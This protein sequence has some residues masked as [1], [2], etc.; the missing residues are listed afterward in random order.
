MKKSK[1]LFLSSLAI[2]TPSITG[3]VAISC[4]GE[5]ANQFADQFVN[6]SN[7]TK[8]WSEQ[9]KTLDLSKADI[10]EIPDGA[11]SFKAL[12]NFAIIRSGSNV[13]IGNIASGLVD[14]ELSKSNTKIGVNGF[15]IE[16]LILPANLEKIGAGAFSGLGKIKTVVFGDK[17]TTIGDEAFSQNAIEKLELP[18][19]VSYIG[20]RAF[21]Q[22]A[23]ASL[24]L[25]AATKVTIL[26]EGVF[27]QNKLTEI[28]LSNIIRVES[29]ALAQNSL[30]NVTISQATIFFSPQTFDYI[31]ANDNSAK[32]AITVQNNDGILNALKSAKESNPKLLYTLTNS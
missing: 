9:T 11:F 27:S 31:G 24:N 14:W 26:N 28:D 32:V 22:N 8:Y 30:T 1:V 12:S 25:N 7:A 6:G 5:K 13:T 2:L 23:I 16:K 21:S 15:N 20:K 3:I 29:G 19:S 18:V 10:K 4:G 17:L